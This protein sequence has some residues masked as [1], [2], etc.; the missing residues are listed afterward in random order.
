[1][2]SMVV[3]LGRESGHISKLHACSQIQPS[4]SSRDERK[5]EESLQ[6]KLLSRHLKIGEKSHL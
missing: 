2:A 6:R 1:M 5:R 3:W 4:S